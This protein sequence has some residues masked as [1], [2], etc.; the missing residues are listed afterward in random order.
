MTQDEGWHDTQLGM[1]YNT[2]LGMT[3]VTKL[4][5]TYDTQREM[6]YDT[7]RWM[8]YDTLW[9]RHITYSE[10]LHQSYVN[11]FKGNTTMILLNSE[12][13]FFTDIIVR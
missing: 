12:V 13:Y 2:Q 8:T 1:T 10:E 5:M 6:T 11:S 4:G 7:Q 9:G 3:Y